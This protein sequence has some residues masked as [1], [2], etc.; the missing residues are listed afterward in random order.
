MKLCN[1]QHNLS[2]TQS[3]L[4]RAIGEL[5][6]GLDLPFDAQ[7]VREEKEDFASTSSSKLRTM[8]RH[9]SMARRCGSK[10]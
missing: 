8:G 10:W 1:L 5:V 3:S 7:S 9:V 2:F 6:E 4:V